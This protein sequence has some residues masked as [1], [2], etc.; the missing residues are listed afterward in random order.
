[1]MLCI[2]SYNIAT[3]TALCPK[4]FF[5]DGS[6]LA[7]ESAMLIGNTRGRYPRWFKW[8]GRGLIAAVEEREILVAS[9]PAAAG[10]YE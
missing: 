6:C 10:F 5:P 1:M 7:R 3:L 8:H 9:T 4:P 2:L